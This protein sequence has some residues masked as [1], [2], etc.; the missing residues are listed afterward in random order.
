MSPGIFGI[1]RFS[2]PK[3]GAIV[4][5]EL[6]AGTPRYMS[7][8]QCRA[9]APVSPKS[10][11]Y[12]LGVILFELLAGGPPYEIPDSDTQ[13]LLDA[14]Q[15]QR[16]RPLAALRPDVPADID[17]LVAAMLAK[18]A[19][20][21]PTMSEVAERLQASLQTLVSPPA[22]IHVESPAAAKVEPPPARQT[23]TRPGPLDDSG[24]PSLGHRV[25]YFLR[26][27]NQK[28]LLRWA[29]AALLLLALAAAVRRSLRPADACRRTTAPSGM[30]CVP[31]GNFQMGSTQAEIAAAYSDCQ[32]FF[33]KCNELSY[34][35]EG[36][37]RQVSLSSFLLAQHEV[38]NAEFT[39]WLNHPGHQFTV[40]NGRQVHDQKK[41]LFDLHPVMNGIAY[42]PQRPTNRFT[43]RPGFE[44][45]P[46][47]YVSWY[48]ANAYCREH[49]WELP[50]E[51]QWEWAAKEAYFGSR[52]AAVG[53][54]PWGNAPPTCDGVVFARTK[55]GKCSYLPP[56]PAEVG[57]AATDL[58]PRGIFDLGGNVEEWVRDR[59]VAPY[60]DCGRCFNPYERAIPD[61]DGTE[62]YAVRGGN[63]AEVA[64]SL[65]VT[66]RTKSPAH[67]L[68]SALGFRCASSLAE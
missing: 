28:S 13:A 27:G 56:G 43:V 55:D 54:W 67:Y 20:R 49:G 5:P 48:G 23:L 16:A 34:L 40:T 44:H 12:A 17:R 8:E 39:I 3:P 64:T 66:A 60:R 45:R 31:G 18:N 15:Y 1:A 11:V 57:R 30:V 37:P 25:R 22:A 2:Q 36:P 24:L 21:R 29:A 38:T 4:E 59:F 50:T 62:V 32:R 7:P 53:I 42:Q 52:L 41:L 47:V 6:L 9:T 58:T 68:S 35:A 61:S 33:D 14:H 26:H 46:V 19:A 51:A 65:R 10:D 63:W